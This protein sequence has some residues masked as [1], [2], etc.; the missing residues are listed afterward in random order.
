MH[1]GHTVLQSITESVHVTSNDKVCSFLLCLS[2]ILV[3]DFIN[4]FL[5]YAEGNYDNAL[6]VER[7]Q[8]TMLLI[9][10]EIFT[11][12]SGSHDRPF[13]KPHYVLSMNKTSWCFLFFG[14]INTV[15]F[16]PISHCCKVPLFK[17]SKGSVNFKCKQLGLVW[18]DNMKRRSET[19]VSHI[20]LICAR[21]FR[22]RY[23]FYV[24]A[25]AMAKPFVSWNKRWVASR[26]MFC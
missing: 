9:C 12:D 3:C 18:V 19:A 25:G 4:H 6:Y 10:T 15:W 24:K 11:R 8:S 17:R 2:C 5:N 26:D 1:F 21:L 20:I 7:D 13:H 16:N 22:V 23:V 14:W